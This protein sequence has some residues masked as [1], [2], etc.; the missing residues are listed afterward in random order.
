MIFRE[1]GDSNLPTIVLLHGG[2][3]SDWSFKDLVKILS[4][5]YH[6][7]TPIIDGHGEAGETDFISIEKSSRNLLD[8]IDTH[9][10]GRVYGLGGLSIGA[11]IVIETLVNRPDIADNVIIESGL[12]YPIK[13]VKALTAPTISMC[14]GLIKYRWFSKMQAKTLFVPSEL[15]EEY[16]KDSLSMSKESLINIIISNG[17]YKLKKDVIN[18]SAKVLIIVGEKEISLMKKSATELNKRIENSKLYIAAK[19]GHGDIS[20][21]H[22]T[23]YVEILENLFSTDI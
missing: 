10:N 15:F 21:N 9:L 13:G 4:E 20:L 12:I 3:L 18:T 7:V 17:T 6:I 22:P 11:Q 19:M 16:Y 23:E 14:Y 1:H 2:G 5:K 8:Y